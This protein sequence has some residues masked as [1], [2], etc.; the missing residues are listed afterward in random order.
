MLSGSLDREKKR[1]P[2]IQPDARTWSQRCWRRAAP[3]SPHREGSVDAGRR[4]GRSGRRDPCAA[5]RGALPE[6]PSACG[7]GPGAVP[8]HVRVERAW[9]IFDNRGKARA[10]PSKLEQKSREEELRWLKNPPESARGKC[11]AL[12]GSEVIGMSE[13][14]AKLTEKVNSMNL[15]HSALVHYIE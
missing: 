12:L 13:S 8:Q 5:Q 7:G 9:S 2:K 4:P 3:D 1:C 15:P 10:V 11:V 6:C 14:L